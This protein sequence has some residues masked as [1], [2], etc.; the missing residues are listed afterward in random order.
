[1]VIPCWQREDIFSIINQQLNYFVE[2]S[3][4]FEFHIIFILSREDPK[5]RKLM[6]IIKKDSDFN[7][8]L[9]YFPNTYLG[10]KTNAGISYA[11]KLG[12]DYLMNIGSDDLIHPA[13]M[14]LYKPY[15]CMN[16]D[17]FGID[18]LYFYDSQ[19]Q[20][21]LYFSYYNSPHV[22]GAGRMISYRTIK[23]VIENIGELYEPTV[24]RGLDTTS[25]LRINMTGVEETNIKAGN[26][27]FICD[28]KSD[29]N[30]NSTN[31]I[32]QSKQ[33][34]NIKNVN[35][36]FVTSNFPIINSKKNECISNYTRLYCRKNNTKCNI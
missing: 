11:Y 17:F 2:N 25:A 21:C 26:F 28:I 3:K 36:I 8:H 24:Q 32:L 6:N 33:K 4:D 22:I 19:T 34:N 12:F 16:N 29:V 7:Y 15:I 23:K 14:Q 9:V 27:P 18:S 35:K 20:K 31:K 1:M 13:I 5:F 10:K 30:I